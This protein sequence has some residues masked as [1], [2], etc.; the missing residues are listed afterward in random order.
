VIALSAQTA[1]ATPIANAIADARAAVQHTPDGSIVS[2]VPVRDHDDKKIKSKIVK[3]KAEKP[4][5]AKGPKA[6]PAKPAKPESGKPTKP[7]PGKPGKPGKEEPTQPTA[8]QREVTVEE[9][10][11]VPYMITD[12]DTP[13]YGMSLEDALVKAAEEEAF[14]RVVEAARS[15]HGDTFLEAGIVHGDNFGAYRTSASGYDAWITFTEQPSEE[16][17]AELAEDQSLNVEIRYGAPASAEELEAVAATAFIEFADE[18]PV[19]AAETVVTEDEIQ[20]RYQLDE[21]KAKRGFDRTTLSGQATKKALKFAKGGELPLPIRY[22]E[23]P[24][25]APSYAAAV[26]RGGER[27]TDANGDAPRC[28]SGFAVQRGT[29]VGVITA[30]HCPNEMRWNGVADVLKFS[31][32]AGYVQLN[33]KEGRVDIQYN[34]TILGSTVAAKFSNGTE[35][36]DV[37][38]YGDAVLGGSVCYYGMMGGYD[39]GTVINTTQKCILFTNVNDFYCGLIAVEG[40]DSGTY[41]DSGGPVFGNRTARGTFSGFNGINQWVVPIS[42]VS[43]KLNAT[44]LTW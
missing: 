19:V 26:V 11:D 3:G 7:E 5:P 15:K 21:A 42:R 23:D 43:G 30:A 27:L 39:C 12:P 41:G 24:E 34:K 16:V 17:L 38:G 9:Y 13:Y 6:E 40:F 37:V 22:V 35:Y 31:V 44:V 20:I 25:L 33:G 14:T 2:A 1:S 36:R 18:T 4:K 32:E 28:T 29:S 8:P 10:P